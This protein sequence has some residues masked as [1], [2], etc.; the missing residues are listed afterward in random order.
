M[1]TY[2]SPYINVYNNVYNVSI[3][4][5]TG[6]CLPGSVSDTGLEPCNTCDIGFYQP[7]YAYFSCQP[8]PDNRTTWRR[9]ARQENE[10]GGEKGHL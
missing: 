4:Y 6:Q 7:M 2:T 9:G 3:I 5:H 8:C 1:Q 10:C